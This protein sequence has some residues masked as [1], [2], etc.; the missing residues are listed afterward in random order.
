[1]QSVSF[2]AVGEITV[3]R[4]RGDL[5]METAPQLRDCLA[6]LEDLGRYSLVVDLQDVTSLDSTVLGVFIGAR[7]R[8]RS[9]GGA[10][11]L[12][13]P[14]EAVRHLFQLIGMS[15]VFAVRDS[16]DEATKILQE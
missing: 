12:V 8:L 6:D 14:S 7:K 3:V 9:H 10:L 11:V 4:V 13:A 15:D 16:V 2:E 5:D 1:M